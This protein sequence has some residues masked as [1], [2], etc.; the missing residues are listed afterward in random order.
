MQLVSFGLPWLQSQK[1]QL[2]RQRCGAPHWCVDSEQFNNETEQPVAWGRSLSGST[3]M[4]DMF[5]VPPLAELSLIFSVCL[6]LTLTDANSSGPGAAEA[7]VSDGENPAP[8][9]FLEVPE[10]QT[11]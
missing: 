11:M 10:G 6:E 9:R 3:L 2:N 4:E 8:S 5:C 7:S 1:M